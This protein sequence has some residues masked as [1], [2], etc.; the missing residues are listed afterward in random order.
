MNTPLMFAI[1]AL[2][3]LIAVPATRELL[4]N[5][6]EN[7]KRARLIPIRIDERKNRR[8]HDR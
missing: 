1:Y 3:G 2:L 4:R 6:R 5:A 8:S 7:A